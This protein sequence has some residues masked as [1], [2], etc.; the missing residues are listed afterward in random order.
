MSIIAITLEVIFRV[1]MLS[2]V[3]FVVC[4]STFCSG[5]IISA[6]TKVERISSIISGRL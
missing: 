5:G 4:G 6:L 2:C 1:N 3:S